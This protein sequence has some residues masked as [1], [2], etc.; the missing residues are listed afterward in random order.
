MLYI[1]RGMARTDPQVN[2]R[3]PERLNDQLKESALQSNRS[4]TQELVTRLEDSFDPVWTALK[5]A[6]GPIRAELFE[7]A[8]RSNISLAE[9]IAARLDRDFRAYG[10][11]LTLNF[12]YGQR[13]PLMEVVETVH[14]VQKEAGLDVDSIRINVNYRD[15]TLADLDSR[16]KPKKAPRKKT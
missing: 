9:E 12:E 11:E 3:I 15:P 10:L 1:V 4:I 16:Q 5:T 14:Q 2:F 7:A 13:P 6:M 8:R